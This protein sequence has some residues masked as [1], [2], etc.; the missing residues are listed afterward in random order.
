MALYAE[1]EYESGEPGSDEPLITVDT[2]GK[3]DGHGEVLLEDSVVVRCNE[4]TLTLQLSM[5]ESE[6]EPLF[7]G[8]CWAGTVVWPAAVALCEHLLLR[9]HRAALPGSRV[10]ELGC[11]LGVPGMVAVLA[12]AQEALLT[13]QKNLVTLLRVNIAAEGN[14]SAAETARLEPRHLSWGAEEARGLREARHAA[15]SGELDFILCCDCVYEPLYGRSWEPLAATIDA[16]AASTTIVLISFERR[17]STVAPDG[18][19]E[20]LEAMTAA[21]FEKALVGGKA[22]LELYEFRRRTVAE[23]AISALDGGLGGGV[24]D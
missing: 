18:I 20:F 16:L 21:G 17:T 14:F 2:T 7:S 4:R 23:G 15:G 24:K 13:E 19:D 22:P 9:R 10:I 6:L 11:G 5:T 3:L 8:E 12:G 1:Y